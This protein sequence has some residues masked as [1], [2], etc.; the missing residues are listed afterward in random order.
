MSGRKRVILA[1]AGEDKS[2][3]FIDVIA[4]LGCEAVSLRNGNEVVDSLGPNIECLVLDAALP[5]MDGFEVARAVRLSSHADVPIL[6]VTDSA[7]ERRRA[8]DGPACADDCIDWSAAPLEIGVRLGYLVG[9]WEAETGLSRN[10]LLSGKT[11]IIED[12]RINE[13][14]ETASVAQRHAYQSQIDAIERLALAAD[15][16]D[17]YSGSHI[18]RISRY[19]EIIA[20]GMSLAGADVETIRIASILHDVGKVGI[21][22]GILNKPGSLSDREWEIMKRHSEIGAHILAGSSSPFLRAGEAIALTHHERWGGAGYPNGLKGASI[23]L[24]GRITAVA[25]V[26]DALTSERPYKAPFS[27]ETSFSIILGESGKHFDPEVVEAFM[28]C[29]SEIVSVQRRFRDMERGRIREKTPKRR[30]RR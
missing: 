15:Y 3:P 21:P 4:L 28:G 30:P 18:L 23:P 13:A 29:T 11:P 12:R 9:A 16:K 5:G 6:F 8:M 17:R 25:D 26:F 20:Q 19:T 22:E 27:N 10:K 14:M 7:R 2:K 24:M 1:L